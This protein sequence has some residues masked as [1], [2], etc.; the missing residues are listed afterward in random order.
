M[1]ETRRIAGSPSF[2]LEGAACDSDLNGVMITLSA[3]ANEFL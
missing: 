3:P 2:E 1:G